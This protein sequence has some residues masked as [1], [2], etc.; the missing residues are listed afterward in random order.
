M[1]KKRR[2]KDRVLIALAYI[3]V[4]MWML[5]ACLVD[6]TGPVG[7][8]AFGGVVLCTAWLGVFGYANH[9]FEGRE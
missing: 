2:W 8:A 1:K 4:F 9:W 5:C 7:A 3:A 6:S